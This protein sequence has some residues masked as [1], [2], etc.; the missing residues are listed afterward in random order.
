MFI[1]IYSVKSFTNLIVSVFLKWQNKRF[2]KII[3]LFISWNETPKHVWFNKMIP[4]Q[5][6]SLK[7]IWMAGVWIMG[8]QLYYFISNKYIKHIYLLNN[9]FAMSQRGIF[10]RNSFSRFLLYKNFINL[11]TNPLLVYISFIVY[12][13][14]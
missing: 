13:S 14:R 6:F 11:S 3:S 2:K 12:I 7:A 8:V 5:F 4:N 10:W 9:R 1:I